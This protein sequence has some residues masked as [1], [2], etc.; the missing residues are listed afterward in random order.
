MNQ[1]PWGHMAPGVWGAVA[2]GSLLRSSLGLGTE[3]G[4]GPPAHAGQAGIRTRVSAQDSD[5]VP[6]IFLGF[7]R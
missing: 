7:H 4:A 6:S 1:V 2:S 5:R 3:A